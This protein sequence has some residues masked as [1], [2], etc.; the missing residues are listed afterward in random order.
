[1]PGNTSTPGPK[2]L[3]ILF[4]AFSYGSFAQEQGLVAKVHLFANLTFSP[5]MLSL[6]LGT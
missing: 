2:H 1:M 4:A 5:Q 3:L 6:P